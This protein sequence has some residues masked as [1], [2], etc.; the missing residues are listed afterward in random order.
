MKKS[1]LQKFTDKR[2]EEFMSKDSNSTPY[3][4][5]T[6]FG[7]SVIPH[8]GEIW[9]SSLVKLLEPLNISERL[10]RTSVFRLAKDNWIEGH[11][12]GRN[13][14]YRPRQTAEIQAAENRIYYQQTKWDGNWRLVVGV[15]MKKA[16]IN[17]DNFR[18]ALLKNGFSSIS[19][20]VFGH[21]TFS[22]RE[23]KN[24][25]EEYEQTDSYL[26]LTAKDS[27]ENPLEFSKVN[28]ILHRH[29]KEELEE[30]YE[31]YIKKYQ[32]IL[33]H[34]EQINLLSPKDSFLIK[35]L[36]IDDYR[37]LLW[38]D[39]INTGILLED[40]WAG[41]RARQLTAS[42]YCEINKKGRQYF[43]MIG[44]DSNGQVPAII[45]RFRK[46]FKHLV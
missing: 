2:L 44:E 40:D 41:R 30:K 24:L 5:L 11:K 18:K 32:Q 28:D 27:D 38:H 7:D 25:L 45:P 19:S 36:M 23:T 39:S 43:R 26:I 35:T 16:T 8:G 42:I 4:I 22:L 33:N 3:L 46:R 6:I 15:S 1:P 21:P 31:N 13:S 14:F 20:N 9:L 17:R 10:A 12:I 34:K 29:T 37:R